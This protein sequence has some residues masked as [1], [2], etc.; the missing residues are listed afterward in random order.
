MTNT[1]TQT[2]THTHTHM[3]RENQTLVQKPDPLR[4]PGTRLTWYPK[5]KSG[6]ESLVPQYFS[7]LQSVLAIKYEKILVIA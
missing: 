7:L 4:Y 2:H 1:H 3:H 5:L 6:I